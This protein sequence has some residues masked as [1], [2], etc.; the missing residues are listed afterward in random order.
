MARPWEPGP[1][2]SRAARCGRCSTS[3]AAGRSPTRSCTALALTSDG[4]PA[5]PDRAG[6]PHG[7]HVDA[8][9]PHVRDLRRRRRRRRAA[10]ARRLGL[11]PRGYATR[12]RR[13]GTPPAQLAHDRLHERLGLVAAAVGD[14]ADDPALARDQ[15]DHRLVDRLGGEQVPGGDGVVLADPVAAVLG[16]VVHRGRPLEVEERD[17]G[18]ARQRDALAAD[19]GGGDEQLRAVGLLERVHR[20]LALVDRVARRP[21]AARPGSARATS[22]CTSRLP[23]NTTSGSSEARKSSIQASAAPELAARG[24]PLEHVQLREPLGAQRRG[25]LA[26]PARR[27]RAA[28]RA[29]TRSRPSRPAGTRARCRAPPARRPGAWRGAAAARRPSAAARSSAGAG[30]S[31]CAPPRPTPWK[32]RAKRAPLPKSSSRPMHAQLGDQLL[33]VVHHR[34][35]RSAPAAARPAPATRPACAPPACAWRAGS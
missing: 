25:D 17:V 34:R 2:S 26:P 30:A 21:G 31:G 24:E 1:T 19:A 20:R 7:R 33:G 32:R 3:A 13:R 29:A 22:S 14:G 28:A 5:R 35:A 12:S 6:R 11:K 4:R 9:R 16:L 27:G 10:R 15:L 8:A 23:Q 18:R